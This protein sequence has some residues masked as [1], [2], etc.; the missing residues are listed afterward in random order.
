M[1]PRDENGNF[2]PDLVLAVMTVLPSGCY[3]REVVEA[4][5]AIEDWMKENNPRAFL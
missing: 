5:N 2:H 3:Q 1:F 4:L